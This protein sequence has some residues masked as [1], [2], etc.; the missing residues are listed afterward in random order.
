MWLLTVG[1]LLAVLG[2][3]STQ[4][5]FNAVD[6]VEKYACNDTVVLPCIVTNLKENNDSSMHVSWK[7]QGQV[8]FSFNGPEQRIYRHE[9]VPSANFLSKADLFKGIASLRLKNAEAPDGNYSCEVTELNR[10]GETKMKLR[11]HME[12]QFDF[13]QSIVIAVLLFF[14]IILCWAQLGVIALKCE[15]VRKKKRHITIA[16]SIF[17]VVA[18]VAVVLFIQD[19]SIS[20]NQIGL[21]FTILPA[22]LLM[23]LQYSIFKMVLDDLT[24]K[25]YAL[26]G[27]QVVGYIVAVVGFALSVSA[28]PSVLLSVVIAGLV[29]M[30]VADLL[31]LAYVYSCSRMKDHQTPR[32]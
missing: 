23:V 7:R 6:F 24:H 12:R 11:T 30:A 31:A 32:Y 10:E 14:I 28:C 9:S 3:G 17:T 29:V 1:A 2:A 19:G 25:G 13:I 8:I 15:T 18:I 20:M 4:L 27:F 5:V 21:A 26:I 16:C 22:G